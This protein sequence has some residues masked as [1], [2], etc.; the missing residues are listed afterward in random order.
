MLYLSFIA[1]TW[2]SESSFHY[3]KWCIFYSAVHCYGVRLSILI[4]DIMQLLYNLRLDTVRVRI[5][6]SLVNK[7]TCTGIRTYVL[8]L[9]TVLYE[10]N[11]STYVY[12]IWVQ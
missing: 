2:F 10:Y 9:Y 3:Y 1:W 5:Y 4:S 8:P 7:L 6:V 12:G 11:T